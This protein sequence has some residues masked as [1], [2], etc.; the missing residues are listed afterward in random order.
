M[1]DQRKRITLT[2]LLYEAHEVELSLVHALIDRRE[3]S[4]AYFWTAELHASGLSERLWDTIWRAYYDFY[5]ATHPML[6]R[7]LVRF[8]GE[9]LETPAL[10]PAAVAVLNLLGR[11]PDPRVLELRLCAEAAPAQSQPMALGLLVNAARAGD[12]RTAAACLRAVPCC[13]TAYEALIC[14]W[15]EREGIDAPPA[16][17]LNP[18]YAH[19]WHSLLAMVVSMATPNDT[20]VFECLVIMPDMDEVVA[21]E[22][23]CPPPDTIDCCYL[24]RERQCAVHLHIGAFALPRRN[25]APAPFPEHLWC[26]WRVYAARCPLWASRLHA[27]GAVVTDTAVV[28]PTEEAKIEFSRRWD[29][30]PDEQPSDIQAAA[31]GDIVA[32][33]YAAWTHA[34]FGREPEHPVPDLPAYA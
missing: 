15:S 32:F 12:L 4:E 31:T 29:A 6:E 20:V 16:S 28:F 33:P 5:A 11:Q 30:A 3:P 2:R 9:Y 21:A 22:A 13:R 8:H 1:S 26:R 24:E 23:S 18:H 17:R 7:Q 10:R 19:L 14:V 34:L 27:A 25:V